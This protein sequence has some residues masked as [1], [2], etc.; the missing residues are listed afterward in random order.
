MAPP[1]APGR[2]A[3][4]A[5]QQIARSDLKRLREIR[6]EQPQDRA[7]IHGTVGSLLQRFGEHREAEV[8]Y[9]AALKSWEDSGRGETV[10]AAAALISFATLLIEDRCLE[11]ARRSVDRAA[12]ILSQSMD[13]APMDHSKLL[14]VCGVLHARRR[15]WPDSE[16]D[17]REALA[18][19]DGQPAVD[20][21]ATS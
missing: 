12:A 3:S 10:D 1:D 13:A 11:E 2:R 15:E 14:M 18:I 21:H 19:A 9:L 16:I 17:F 5:R 20:A 6:P 7:L 4:G 8:E